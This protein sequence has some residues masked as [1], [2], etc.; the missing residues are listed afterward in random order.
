MWYNL[1]CVEFSSFC[2]TMQHDYNWF[3][4]QPALKPCRVSE[5]SKWLIDWLID[6]CGLWFKKV[7][8]HVTSLVVR[9]C[10]TSVAGAAA[11]SRSC[12][13][14]SHRT[15]RGSDGKASEWVGRRPA[16]LSCLRRDA[17]R[18]DS[19]AGATRWLG[20]HAGYL[21]Y[22]WSPSW[23]VRPIHSAALISVS[24]ALSQITAYTA[25]PRIRSSCIARCACVRPS[26][27][28]YSLCL[29]MEGWPGWVC[30]GGLVT[31]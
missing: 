13:W 12:R 15:G 25:R 4:W 31:V 17:H 7:V 20:P 6:W 2:W 30:M 10:G 26:F 19:R 22:T 1:L 16:E 28:W 3:C 11:G 23:A 14:W 29:P 9:W 18:T 24:L 5:P 27:C 8:H 21:D